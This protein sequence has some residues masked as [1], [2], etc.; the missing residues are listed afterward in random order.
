MNPN[1]ADYLLKKTQKDYNQVAKTFS[2]TREE[3]WP[4][5]WFFKDFVQ[6]EEKILDVGCGSGRLYKLF[7][8]K[9]IE[10]FGVDFAERLIEIARKKYLASKELKEGGVPPVFLVVNA[11]HLPFEDN[12]FDKVFSIAVLHHIPS[13]KQRVLFLKEI[14]RVLKPK[15][16]LFLTVWNLWQVKYL[17]LILKWTLLK[18]LGLTRV[19][20]GDIFVPFQGTERYYHCFRKKELEKAARK[21]YFGDIKVKYLQRNEQNFNIFLRAKKI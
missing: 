17:P 12:F 9:E 7:K 4:E 6:P 14:R 10:Y 3:T 11:L 5:I 20:Y 8:G 19:D 18:F 21:A 16:E 2:S 1:F 13:D 15:G